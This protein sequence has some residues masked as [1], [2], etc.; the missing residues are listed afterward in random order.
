[1]SG[2]PW[3]TLFSP[4]ALTVLLATGTV[5]LPDP[6]A[7]VVDGFATYGSCWVLGF[8]YQRGFLQALPRVAT[9]L[10]A[11]LLMA[12]GF[13]W[14]AGH[15][16]DTGWDLG[17]IP[18]AQALWSFGFCV[19]LLRIS[20]SW[21]TLPRPLRIFD[22][23]ITLINNRAITIYLWHIVLLIATV[24]LID[25]LWNIPFLETSFSWLLKSEALQFAAVWL[26]LGLVILAVGWAEDVA[27]RRPPRLW[28]S[29][30]GRSGGAPRPGDARNARETSAG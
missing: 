23:T 20:P 5:G 19:L 10:V 6:V 9:P 29:G 16:G 12:A 22:G 3:V 26:M 24:P 30:K 21:S 4:L 2:L 15:L 28:P 8:A 14:A 27:A 18:L 13:W 25:Q 11:M 17:A 7:S 1:M